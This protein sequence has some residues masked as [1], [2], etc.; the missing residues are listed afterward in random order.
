M[1]EPVKEGRSRAF[2]GWVWC[3]IGLTLLV[4]LTVRG[5]G[6]DHGRAGFHVYHPDVGKLAH[7]SSEVYHARWDAQAMFGEDARFAVYPYGVSV[8]TGTLLR[9]ADGVTGNHRTAYHGENP[10]SQWAWAYRLR[11]FGLG[12]WV[13]ATVAVLLWAVGRFRPL[14]CLWLACV[15]A[16]EPIGAQ[17]AHY[18]MNDIPL[19]SFLLIAFVCSAWMRTPGWRGVVSAGLAGLFFG[20]AGGV[21]YQAVIAGLFFVGHVFRRPG[22]DWFRESVIPLA[23]VFAGVVI[24]FLVTTP[25]LWMHPSYFFELLPKFM[26]WQSQ[27]VEVDVGVWK[28]AQNNLFEFFRWMGPHGSWLLFLGTAFAGWRM[29]KDAD[30]R[31][32]GLHAL[33]FV[34]VMF[35]LLLFTRAYARTNDLLIML[36]FAGLL[37]AWG[38]DRF[39]RGPRSTL[40]QG[41]AW[42]IIVWF[43]V[44][45][46]LDSRALTQPDT[47]YLAQQWLDEHVK[48][49]DLVCREHYTLPST[50]K[51]SIDREY[52]YAVYGIFKRRLMEGDFQYAVLSSMANERFTNHNSLWYS[53]KH[54]HFY[55]HVSDTHNLAVEF[56]NRSMFI[57]H[58]DIRIFEPEKGAP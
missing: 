19:V 12:C 11:V 37:S 50:V 6:L 36:P 53:S 32:W 1:T 2:S 17:F 46:G 33:G 14:V 18:G 31:E 54:I 44:S 7:V 4:G 9:W 52:G 41:L 42:S 30:G 5:I 43:G 28:K 10:E 8:L 48:P 39:W 49:D 40:I 3:L 23:G 16:L 25:T 20:M 55:N 35:A 45:A 51:G 58:P 34:C 27:L 24:G 29:R 56:S 26:A 22:E 57:A 21:K 38:L 13:F 15:L 47:R